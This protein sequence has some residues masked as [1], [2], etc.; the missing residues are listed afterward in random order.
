MVIRD[1]SSVNEAMVSDV[2]PVQQEHPGLP[3]TH[4]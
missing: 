2:S 1:V 3:H 4:A